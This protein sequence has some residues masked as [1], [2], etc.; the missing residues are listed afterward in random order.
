M[1]QI[2][3]REREGWLICFKM[4]CRALDQSSVLS[5]TRVTSA[6]PILTLFSLMLR[7]QRAAWLFGLDHLSVCTAVFLDRSNIYKGTMF[8]LVKL[9]RILLPEATKEAGEG[10]DSKPRALRNMIWQ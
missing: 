5:C 6:Y 3:V 7:E 2:V 4:G 8:N 10:A 9:M 1:D